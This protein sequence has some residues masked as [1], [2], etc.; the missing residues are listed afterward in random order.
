VALIC[1]WE[2][3]CT[4]CSGIIQVG[5]DLYLIDG[6]KVCGLCAEDNGYVCP[7]CANPKKPQYDMCY[8]C[9]KEGQ[10]RFIPS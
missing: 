1:K 9:K 3:T 5:D 4:W 6:E 2:S 7:H 10:K 8:A